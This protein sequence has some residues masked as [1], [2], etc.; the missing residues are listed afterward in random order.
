MNNREDKKV[1]IIVF[2]DY[3]CPFCKMY[4]RKVSPKINKDYLETNKASY[5][6]VNAQLLG[7]ES[8]QAS[9]ASYAVY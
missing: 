3:Q 7:K 8:E 6:F 1:E 4:E 5:H 2:G 9:R